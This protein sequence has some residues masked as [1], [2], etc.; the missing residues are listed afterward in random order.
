MRNRR[1]QFRVN[2]SMFTRR[3]GRNRD[4]RARR[5]AVSLYRSNKTVATPCNGLHKARIRCHV[6]QRLP[7]LIHRRVKAVI[8]VYERVAGP[9]PAAQFFPR[10]HLTRTLQHHRQNLERLFLQLDAAAILAQLAACEVRLKYSKTNNPCRTR[11]RHGDLDE[12]VVYHRL[13]LP[14]SRSR[15]PNRRYFV[16]TLFILVILSAAKDLL[17]PSLSSSAPRKLA[18]SE[19]EGDLL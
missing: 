12:A 17:F 18:L 4:H 16:P 1:L 9:Q 3:C 5:F 10:H 15:R 2:R 6:S 11:F 13:Y 7:D 19:V 14:S 8:K